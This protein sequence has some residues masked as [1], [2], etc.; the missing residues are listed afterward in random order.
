MLAQ[1]DSTAGN[2]ADGTFGLILPEVPHHV[3]GGGRG[4]TRE[5]DQSVP[6]LRQ[7]VLVLL[8]QV[9]G[10]RVCHGDREKMCG[11]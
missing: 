1:G 2:G 5:I 4:G 10:K 3:H 9:E 7:Q 11:L 6:G 8:R